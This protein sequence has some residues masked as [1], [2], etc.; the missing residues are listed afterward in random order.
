MI[1]SEPWLT[2]DK[3]MIDILKSI[4]IEK[5][6]PLNPDAKTQ[7][8]FDEAAAEAHAWLDTRYETILSS[9][10]YDGSQW[11]LPAVREV[12]EGQQTFFANPDSYPIDDRGVSYSMAFFSPKHLGTGSFYLMA[13]KDA[14]RQ[15]LEGANTYQLSVPANAPVNQYWSA[16]AYD[17][18]T[19]ARIR[20]MPRPPDTYPRAPI[21]GKT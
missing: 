5:R 17:R 19:Y 14:D 1:Q 15:P 7:T 12:L 21:C 8:M 4:G 6:K 11:A 3:A 13:I 10:F 20:D 2:R 16:T 9:G 18:A